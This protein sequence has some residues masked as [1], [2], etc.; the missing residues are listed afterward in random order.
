MNPD[1]VAGAVTIACPNCGTSI[2][3]IPTVKILRIDSLSGQGIVEFDD[4]QYEHRCRGRK[5]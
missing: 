5:P 2:L 3:L 1:F 4:M